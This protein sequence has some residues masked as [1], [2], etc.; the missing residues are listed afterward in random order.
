MQSCWL[1]RL[2][3]LFPLLLSLSGSDGFL[4]SPRPFWKSPQGLSLSGTVSS[5]SGAVSGRSSGSSLSAQPRPALSITG[6]TLFGAT[7]LR[8]DKG[9]DILLPAPEVTASCVIHFV[10]GALAGAAPKAS[11]LE[12]LEGVCQKTGAIIVATPI[13]PDGFRDHLR[14][15]VETA[16]EFRRIVTDALQLELEEEADGEGGETAGKERGV[17]IGGQVIPVVGMGHSLGGKVLLLM[18]SLPESTVK[19]LDLVRPSS[20]VFLAFNNFPAEKAV[21]FL[22]ETQ[23]IL[24][25]LGVGS[26][27][28]SSPSSFYSSSPAVNQGDPSGLGDLVSG[29]VSGLQNIPPALRGDDYYDSSNARQNLMR[30]LGSLLAMDVKGGMAGSLGGDPQMEIFGAL[31][32]FLQGSSSDLQGFR[33]SPTP[34]EAMSICKE[35][36]IVRENVIVQFENDGIDQSAQLLNALQSSAGDSLEGLS[37]VQLRGTHTTPNSDAFLQ[38][39]SFLP[40]QARAALEGGF[41]AEG[42]E[43]T[44]VAGAE[45]PSVSFSDGLSGPLPPSRGAEIESLIWEVSSRIKGMKSVR[46]KS[47]K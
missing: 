18:S 44:G 35:G 43:G 24:S 14:A 41:G 29:F 3:L 36:N 21:P 7:W 26:S 11:Y 28:S 33:F 45:G 40:Q 9:V 46:A 17:R 23:M 42:G 1:S 5:L 6:K 20:N 4:L 27:P 37:F 38:L 47:G 8:S 15:A 39:L 12:V 2:G 13:T 30:G 22:R 32:A 10:G 16:S 19:K 34:R 25:S 31:A